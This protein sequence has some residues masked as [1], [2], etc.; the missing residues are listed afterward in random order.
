MANVGI[1]RTED[2]VFEICLENEAGQERVVIYRIGTVGQAMLAAL[3]PEQIVEMVLKLP[4]PGDPP[5][6]AV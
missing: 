1:V 2:G 5:T 4:G 6:R 3:T